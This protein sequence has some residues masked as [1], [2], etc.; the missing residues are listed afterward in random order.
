MTYLLLFLSVYIG[1]VWVFIVKPKSSVT[2]L[3][4][5]FSG[6]YLLSIT[7]LELFPN[8][9]TTSSDFKK[10][11]VFILAGVLLQSL[12]E[13]FSKGAEHGHVHSHNKNASFPFLLFVSLSIHAF[14]EGLPIH[15]VGHNLLGAII[16][17][18]VPVS[19]VLT[20]YFINK[21]Y[22][23]SKIFLY[24][25]LF[26][27][28][29]PLGI[30]FSEKIHFLQ[31]YITEITALTIGIFLHISTIILFET[32]ENHSFNLKKFLVIILGVLLT[33]FTV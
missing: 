14:T 15:H 19:I 18:K 4:L 20:V 12:L 30:L 31:T 22:S 2:Q 25:S 26:A 29:S 17:H 9:Y 23:K 27:I 24:L 11:G 8:V 1:L 16:I 33:V 5:A 32:S 10:I 21:G 28:M 7:V 13:S 6:A 3:L